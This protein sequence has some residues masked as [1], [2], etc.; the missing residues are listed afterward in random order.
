MIYTVVTINSMNQK[1][2]KQYEVHKNTS[3]I[4][5]ALC[6]HLMIAEQRGVLI[7]IFDDDGQAQNFAVL[8]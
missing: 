6:K 3:E 5:R 1:V 8:C 4:V 7:N 2:Q